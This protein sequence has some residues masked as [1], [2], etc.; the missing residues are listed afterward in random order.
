MMQLSAITGTQ[1]KKKE[2]SRK[3]S[4]SEKDDALPAL[5]K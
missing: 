4:F 3:C 2:L 1:E 5:T